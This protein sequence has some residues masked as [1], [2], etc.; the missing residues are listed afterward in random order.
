VGP[1][2]CGPRGRSS[3]PSPPVPALTGGLSS[4][5]ESGR[6]GR[7]CGN[8]IRQGGGG[9][10]GDRARAGASCAGR[11]RRPP[12]SPIHSAVPGGRGAPA[13]ISAQQ[14]RGRGAPASAQGP[15]P[16]GDTLPRRR[17]LRDSLP[18]SHHV[19]PRSQRAAGRDHFGL[20][21]WVPGRPLRPRANWVGPSRR[22]WRG[23]GV[24]RGEAGPRWVALQ[25]REPRAPLVRVAYVE[26]PNGGGACEDPAPSWDP[27]LALP[28][29][30]PSFY[31]CLC[32]PSDSHLLE[33]CR[34]FLGTN[35]GRAFA[36]SEISGSPLSGAR[37]Q[38]SV[39]SVLNAGLRVGYRPR[40]E[41][42][43]AFCRVDSPPLPHASSGVGLSRIPAGEGRQVV[44]PSGPA[45]WGVPWSPS[46]FGT[47]S[48][49]SQS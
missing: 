49:A 8:L 4:Q 25:P 37:P 46:R 35:P 9:G 34:G 2:L 40:T 10:A 7:G 13:A 12:S 15:G 38:L 36:L 42:A 47:S 20:R 18:T 30:F 22:A 41:W 23:T 19:R 16:A 21:R 3:G 27:M 29:E 26:D 5:C 45:Q 31:C 6:P 33:G 1:G 43:A 44:Q 11:G 48:S 14:K 24:G 28:P 39:P 17:P 32:L